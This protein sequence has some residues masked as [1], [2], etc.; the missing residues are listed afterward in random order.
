MSNNNNG[1]NDFNYNLKNQQQQQ[2]F[3][4]ND[5]AE[6]RLKRIKP[7]WNKTW[8]SYTFLFISIILSLS[9]VIGSFVEPFSI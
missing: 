3:L 6:L 1:R 9:V 8:A 7:W 5:I 2:Q 4:V